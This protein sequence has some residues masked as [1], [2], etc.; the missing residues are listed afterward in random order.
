MEIRETGKGKGRKIFE[1]IIIKNSLNLIRNINQHTKKAQ[2]AS[3]KI[4]QRFIL[5]H[6]HMRQKSQYSFLKWQESDLPH[7]SIS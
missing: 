7:K 5:E 1:D 2:K 4:T 6:H 3:S